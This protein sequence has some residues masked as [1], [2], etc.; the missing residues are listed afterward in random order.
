METQNTDIEYKIVKPETILSDYVERFY[1]VANN[2]SLDKEMVV[3]PDG[4][5]DLFFLVSD[6]ESIRCKL[7]GLETKPSTVIFSAKTK[8]LGVSFNLL[9]IEYI[10]NSSIANI[11]NNA[12]QLPANFWDL[13]DKDLSNFKTFCS[14]VS[15]RIINYLKLE[16]DNRK[17]KLF[18]LIYSTNGSLTVK[19]YSE[20][21]F[22]SSRQINRYFNQTFGL[23]LKACCNIL[24]FR[25]SFQQIKDGKLYPEQNFSDQAHFT[26]EV[27]KLSG[28]VPKE[29]SKNKNDRFVQ[30]SSI[31]K[32]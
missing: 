6:K 16:T 7:L 2:S 5:I 19:E 27:K 15:N 4:R 32:K 18:D 23:S 17:K 11:L 1:F 28:V 30:F 20:K 29:L 26:R 25:A 8:I 13:T 24:R 21:V 14:K 22:W 12:K 10:F 9:A 3:I 31:L